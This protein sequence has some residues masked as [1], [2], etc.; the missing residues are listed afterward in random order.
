MNPLTLNL[1]PTNVPGKCVRVTRRQF[2][3]RLLL[4]MVV[5][6]L[7]ATLGKPTVATAQV[8][9]APAD[10]LADLANQEII[11]SSG[12]ARSIRRPGL[13]WT[14]NDSGGAARLYLFDVAGRDLGVCDL[15]NLTPVDWE[16]MGAF[17]T[18]RAAYLFVAD[19]G[20]NQHRR[21]EYRI[22][23]IKE[24]DHVPCE[25]ETRS[26]TFRYPDGA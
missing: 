14:H 7:Q 23:L 1:R 17:A 4:V 6:M 13:L 16:D 24:P 12:V 2:S 18:E 15:K 19:V 10:K 3:F 11:E 8:R 9:Y 26:I 22:D 25:V 21:T 5:L 20:D